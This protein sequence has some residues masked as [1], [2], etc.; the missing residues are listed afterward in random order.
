MPKGENSRLLITFF[1]GD[2]FPEP[3]LLAV[4]TW[5]KSLRFIR[6]FKRFSRFASISTF[7]KYCPHSLVAQCSWVSLVALCQVS[8]RCSIQSFPTHSQSAPYSACYF[9]LHPFSFPFRLFQ[10]FL[11]GNPLKFSPEFS[12]S[13]IVFLISPPLHL[14]SS[15]FCLKNHSSSFLDMFFAVFLLDFRPCLSTY[16]FRMQSISNFLPNSSALRAWMR[17]SVS[18]KSLWMQFLK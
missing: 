18:L 6:F 13:S 9:F 11:L 5:V 4:Y 3:Y 15:L 14:R 7:S 16:F 1:K 17:F 10:L 8:H 2:W 12:A